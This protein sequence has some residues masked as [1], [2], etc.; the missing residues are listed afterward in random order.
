MQRITSQQNPSI[1]RLVSLKT[2]KGRKTHGQYLIEGIRLVREAVQQ[3]MSLAILAVQD[4]C[5]EPY[6]DIVQYA[7]D[8]GAEI[9]IVPENV[10]ARLCNTDHP[11]GLCAALAMPQYAEFDGFRMLALDSI[12]DPGNMGTIMRT[13]AAFG[14]TDVLLSKGCADAFAPKCVRAGMGAHFRLRIHTVDVLAD[15]LK[16]LGDGGFEIIGTCV[17]GD[18]QLHIKGQKT[19]CVIGNEAHGLSDDVTDQCTSL[20]RIPMTAGSESLNAAVAAGIVLFQCYLEQNR[21]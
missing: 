19:L 4:D 12:A 1:K 20:Y 7:Q 9:L 21:D 3:T 8:S 6:S 18:E 17:D 15:V 2:V 11:Q 10:M 14:V 16:E 13:A 5:I